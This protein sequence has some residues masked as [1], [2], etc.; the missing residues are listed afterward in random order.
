MT[1]P[2]GTGPK[3]TRLLLR[4]DG[5]RCEGWMMNI[6]EGSRDVANTAFGLEALQDRQTQH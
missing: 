4:R 5:E 3:T 6:A 2:R 1:I